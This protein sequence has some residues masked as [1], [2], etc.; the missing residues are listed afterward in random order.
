MNVQ[1]KQERYKKDAITKITLEGTYYFN[2][3]L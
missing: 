1:K 2:D 3:M